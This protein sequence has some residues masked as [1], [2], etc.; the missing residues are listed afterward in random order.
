MPSQLKDSSVSHNIS[1]TVD[2]EPET[3]D[4]VVE[5]IEDAEAEEDWWCAA[6]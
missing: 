4:V 3:E 1:D 5:V 2:V 6:V